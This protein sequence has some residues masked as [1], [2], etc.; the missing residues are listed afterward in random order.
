MYHA[1]IPATLAKAYRG[2]EQRNMFSTL[3]GAALIVLI[4]H[5][6]DA[7][8][9]LVTWSFYETGITACNAQF[10]C[11]LP[12]PPKNQIINFTLSNTTET[13]SAVLTGWPSLPI[14]TDPNFSLTMPGQTDSITPPLWL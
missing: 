1:P 2:E 6:P 8:A 7:R 5:S 13:G 3:L 9:D 14:V 11:S 12:A 10:G 4:I